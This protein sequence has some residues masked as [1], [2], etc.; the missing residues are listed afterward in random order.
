MANRGLKPK[1]IYR[2]SSRLEVFYT[3]GATC[4]SSNGVLACA[5]ND[6]VKVR[7]NL[8]DIDEDIGSIVSIIFVY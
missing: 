8:C 2:P 7:A 3:G 4:I 5:C 1:S 6:E